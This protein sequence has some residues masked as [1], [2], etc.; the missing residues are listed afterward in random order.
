[1]TVERGT[2]VLDS[3]SLRRLILVACSSFPGRLCIRYQT[4]EGIQ[5]DVQ[6]FGGSAWVGRYQ[7][8]RLHMDSDSVSE[9][10]AKFELRTADNSW[11][12][13]DNNSSNGTRLNGKPLCPGKQYPLSDGD[14]VLLGGAREMQLQV[15]R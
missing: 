1:M 5:K 10:H 6:L 4:A 15:R 14:V 7:Y 2:S 11:H 13:T 8:L 12:I 3:E 9:K